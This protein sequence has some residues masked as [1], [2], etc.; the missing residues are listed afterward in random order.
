[1]PGRRS[2]A[3]AET[4]CTRS[5]HTR[6][7]RPVSRWLPQSRGRQR[8][9]AC[10]KVRPCQ[11]L[12]VAQIGTAE[13]PR[14]TCRQTYGQ[15]CATQGDARCRPPGLRSAVRRARPRAAATLVGACA[16]TR[17]LWQQPRWSSLDAVDLA[18]EFGTPVPTMHSV[19]VFLRSSVRQAVVLALRALCEA[20]TRS[21]APANPSLE[22]VPARTAPAAPPPSRNWHGPFATFARLPCWTLGHSAQGHVR[23]RCRTT[24]W[25]RSKRYGC[26]L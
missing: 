7:G 10:Q 6:C 18:A 9:E 25:L 15:G 22:I 21:T 23:S 20:Y 1:M 5:C 4:Q 12:S 13:S 26:C 14:R 16:A 19:P 24:C 11:L 2:A 8:R 3:C 17:R